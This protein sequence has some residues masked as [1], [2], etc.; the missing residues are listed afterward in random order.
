MGPEEVRRGPR[1]GH[2]RFSRVMLREKCYHE[3]MIINTIEHAESL[4]SV[5]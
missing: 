2:K 4:Q 5:E 3:N 1:V